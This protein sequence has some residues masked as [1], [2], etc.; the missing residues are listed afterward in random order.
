MR[1]SHS[2]IRTTALAAPLV[3]ALGVRPGAADPI[4]YYHAGAWHAFTDKDANGKDICGI[5]TT[6]PTDGRDFA[7]TY[8]IGGENLTFR[9]TKPSWTVPDGTQLNVS[10]QID[11]N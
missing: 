4:V 2:V 1:P 6:N 3:L 9:A 8:L 11:Q 5:A 10:M 7:L